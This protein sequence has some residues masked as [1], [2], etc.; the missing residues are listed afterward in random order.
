[1]SGAGDTKQVRASS[2]ETPSRKLKACQS[3]RRKIAKPETGGGLIVDRDRVTRK[4]PSRKGRPK[5]GGY[6]ALKGL[7]RS[8]VKQVFD[9][10]KKAAEAGTPLNKFV[11]IHPHDDALEADDRS[12]K[13]WLCNKAKDIIQAVRGRN[14]KKQRQ[15]FVPC[16]TVYEKRCGGTLHCHML[17]HVARGNGALLRLSDG[18]VIDS[19][20]ANDAHFGYITKARLPSSPEFEATTTHRRQGGQA[21][22]KGVRIS[23]NADAK[24]LLDA[25]PKAAPEAAERD[26][27]YSGERLDRRF[28]GNSRNRG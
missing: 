22:I 19:R 10:R 18:L 4:R 20:P 13:R 26:P 17:L 5:N 11:T 23:F 21:A 9:L 24:A 12:C 7:R 15:P 1:M 2:L 8:Q 25:K 28:A 14:K 16:V 6:K 27:S 3:T